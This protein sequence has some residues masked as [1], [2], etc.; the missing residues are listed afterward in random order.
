MDQTLSPNWIIEQNFEMTGIATPTL[1][2]WTARQ[3]PISSIKKQLIDHQGHD[4]S[5]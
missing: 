2:T 4:V 5:G 3:L 1:D